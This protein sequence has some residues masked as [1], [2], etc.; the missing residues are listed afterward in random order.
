[1]YKYKFTTH[2]HP[3]VK[4]YYPRYGKLNIITGEKVYSLYRY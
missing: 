4:T 1:M 3:S 2:V